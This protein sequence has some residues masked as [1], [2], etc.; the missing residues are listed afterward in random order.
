MKLFKHPLAEPLPGLAAAPDQRLIL[1]LRVSLA[2]LLIR[3][4]ELAVNFYTLLFERHPALRPMFPTD[5]AD[6]CVKLTGM[7][8]FIISGLDRPEQTIEAI[9]ALGR[10][11][12]DYA[13]K[14][15]HYPLVRDTLIEA[16][17]KTAAG[18]WDA[19]LA[20]DWRQSM[21]LITRHMLAATTSDSPV[22]QARM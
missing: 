7:L 4:D 3:G 2:G 5:M 12:A 16:M 17:E 10:R 14:P 11:H 15:E 19:E 13:T 6:Q 18:K 22:S 21:D 20:E 1:R 9:R 8:A